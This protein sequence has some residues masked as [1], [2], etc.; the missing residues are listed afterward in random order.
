MNI[1][2]AEP[3]TADGRAV[4]REFRKPVVTIGRDATECDIAFDKARFPMVSRKH[5]EIR[6][7]NGQWS[8]SDLGST[9][10]TFQNGQPVTQPEPL[11]A[12]STLQFGTDGP[13]LV[14]VWFEVGD[15]ARQTPAALAPPVP[16]TQIPQ[17]VPPQAIPKMPSVPPVVI[18]PAEL[19]ISG[20][21]AKPTL[22][23]AKPSILLGREADCDVIFDASSG[24]VSRR[25]AEI[26]YDGTDFVV[27]DNKSFNGTLVNGQRIST[28]TPLYDGDQIQ[29]GLGGPVV[30]FTSPGR[31]APKGSSLA[32]QRS[33][34]GFQSI[35]IPAG[36]ADSPKT[37]VA[38]LGRAAAKPMVETSSDP[39]LLMTL[40]FGNKSELTIGRD[41]S[42]DIRIDGLQISKHHAKLRLYGGEVFV[43]DLN[44]TN[45][46]FINGS[47]TN[48]QV[49][50]PNDNVQIGP[51]VIRVDQSGS[52]GVFDARSKMRIDVV[53]VGRE[54]KGRAGA[55]IRV[56]DNVSFSI[57]PN[58]FV[59]LLGP[60]GAGKSSLIEAM[61]GVA[62]AK[63]GN[64][65]VNNLD[66]AR[67]FD[68]LK[69]AIGYVPQEDIIHRELSV[70]RTL[71]YVARLRLSRDVNKREIDQI[72][73][74]VID[75]TGLAERKNVSVGKL[76]GGQ[77]KR[78]S[79]A[80]ELITK[81]SCIFLDEP[82]SGLDPATEDRIMR[83]FK[84]VAESGRT[85][86]MTTH[87]MENV[88]MFDKI[89][90]LMRGCLVFFG[91]PDDALSH[92][93]AAS[94]KELYDRLE[95]PVEAGIREHGERNR[96]GLEDQAADEWRR[97]YAG[98]AQYKQ[99]VEEPLKQIGQLHQ[100]KGQ[101]RRR[102]GIFGSIR[103]WA[104]LSRR[105]FE[106]LRK[107][108][109]NLFIM[110]AQP[111]V[112][113][114]LTFIVMGE[115][116]PRDFVYFVIALVAVWFGVSDSAREIVRELPVYKRERMFNL[117][118]IPYLF[119]KLFVLGAIVFLQCLILYVPLKFFDLVGAMPMPGELG[120]IPQFWAMLLSGFVGLSTGLFISSLFRSPQLATT[121]VP[122]I[123][124]P[125][126]LFSG[127]GGVPQGLNKVIS[128]TMPAAWSFDT[129]KRFSTL[130]TLEPEGAKVG[131]KGLGLYK[132]VESENEKALNKAKKDLENFKAVS[133]RNFQQN[134]SGEPTM[135]DE[136]EV[137]EMKKVPA[138]LSGYITFLHPWMNEVLNQLVLMLMFWIMTIA[139]LI[140]LKLK[141][142]R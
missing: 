142:L 114:V 92:F 6:L 35:S 41:E 95:E 99:F 13:K 139:T 25:H 29:L 93:K 117:G 113:A 129:M 61:N 87:A 47:R 64:V 72:V 23:I 63:F 71:Y 100:G 135:A 8:I 124:I 88:K 18:P 56:L 110:L 91:K 30:I 9:Y 59:G 2:L 94:F 52:V 19:E 39:Q 45:G 132:F 118:I 75:V 22:T 62:P 140:V 111:P 26:A 57:Q 4:D 69:Q 133:G 101:K 80:V 16:A 14:V 24:T 43:E 20:P 82:T 46:V 31:A 12:G 7:L 107:D 49:V 38:N 116:W 1:I 53:G 60:S 73:N 131:T 84:Q 123:L 37:M 54:V 105:Y 136:L 103:Q 48:R 65:L 120:G 40:Q 112:I 68:S 121:L 81:P 134:E 83:L 126:I 86:V 138:N 50:R 108:R 5:A 67:H 42:N 79:I 102:L 76:S 32:G 78:V 106:V 77:R 90:V 85:V 97:K 70:Y 34:Q 127:I 36:A 128:M 104:T 96:P 115:N 98:T 21:A 33:V 11:M 28:Q 122:L 55:R 15:E 130:D 137:P 27:R 10:G 3:N 109:L 51:F 125:Q 89:A 17:P 44:S 66:L 58:E 119:S 74:E 141:D